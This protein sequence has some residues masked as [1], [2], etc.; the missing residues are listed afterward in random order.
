MEDPP[1]S[2]LKKGTLRVFSL[3]VK[4]GWGGSEMKLV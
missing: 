3:L 2:P 1:K 4:G